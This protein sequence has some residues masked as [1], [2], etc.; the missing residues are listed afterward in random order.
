MFEGTWGH[1]E[2]IQRGV[3]T[4]SA[5]PAQIS[6][7][8]WALGKG[9]PAAKGAV[10]EGSASRLHRLR[11][12][13]KRAADIAGALIGLV[14][15]APFFAVIAL[16]IASSS[17]GPVLFFQTRI[18][19]DGV[20][21]R[22][23]KF[24]TLS[25][26]SGASYRSQVLEGD[27]RITPIGRFLRQNRFDELPQLWNVLIGEMSIVGPR[28]YTPSMRVEGRRYADIAPDFSTRHRVRP[29]LT[30]WAQANGFFG[31]VLTAASGRE[32]LDHDIAYVHNLSL[33]LDALIVLM[34]LANA[35]RGRRAKR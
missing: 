16:A 4:N 22:I 18:G 23:V 12:W 2:D 28:P 32:R 34:T 6:R 24:R 35:L 26:A 10:R 21:F 29:G 20:P 15:L 7:I 1:K 25:H 30:G 17:R 8:G 14:L 5:L 11:L 31:P 13:I 27:P 3:G 19:K 33:G 9:R